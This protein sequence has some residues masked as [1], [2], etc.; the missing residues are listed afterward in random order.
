MSIVYSRE[1]LE[2]SELAAH[3]EALRMDRAIRKLRD[4]VTGTAMKFHRGQNRNLA[5]VITKLDEASM[6]AERWLEE[7]GQIAKVDRGSLIGSA[8]VATDATLPKTNTG[9]AENV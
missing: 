9:G 6:W 2:E 5:L 7:A 3:P 4:E 8:T 1:F